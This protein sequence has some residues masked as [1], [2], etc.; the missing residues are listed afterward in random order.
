MISLSNIIKKHIA[1][2]SGKDSFM[3]H[4]KPIIAETSDSLNDDDEELPLEEEIYDPREEIE[5]EVRALN[6]K[7]LSLE[8]EILGIE[9]DID[10]R[11]SEVQNEIRLQQ[12]A[13]QKECE[14][15][16]EETY[17]N[18]YDSGYQE[19]LL[20]GKSAYNERLE[21]A[22]KIIG[23]SNKDYVA[24]I[25]DSEEV[26]MKLAVE[27]ANRVLRKNLLQDESLYVEFVKSALKQVKEMRGIRIR[28]SPDNYE[29]ILKYKNELQQLI[30]IDDP[31]YIIPDDDIGVYDCYI[32]SEIGRV[33]V[34]LDTQIKEMKSRLMELLGGNEE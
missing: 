29:R 32:D 11:L 25:V 4:I 12:E 33:D 13:F 31:I 22:Q 34:S 28:V 27:I 2:S 1:K 18:A 6:E 30:T 9:Q 21:E 5:Q 26:I 16:K 14:Q 17:Q 10:M 8:Q 23:L 19:G 7:K 20:E 3:I 24:N 15:L